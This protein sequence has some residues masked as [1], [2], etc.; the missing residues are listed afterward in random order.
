GANLRI[1]SGVRQGDHISVHYDP[2]IAKL[3]VWDE[4]RAGA[5][6]RLRAALAA[7]EVVGVTTNA[8]FLSAI[9]GHPAFAAG[10]VDTGFIPRHADILLPPP[11]TLSDPVL[12]LSCLGVLLERRA[13]A[14]REAAASNDPYSPWAQC[15]GWRLNEDAHDSLHL[16][17][18][19]TDIVLPLIY[20]T[21]GYELFLPGGR[22]EARG[23]L[24]AEG[25]LSAEIGPVRRN[26]GFVQRGGALFLFVDGRCH[27]LTLVDPLPSDE[28][29]AVAGG[30]TAVMHGT[31]IALLV[32]PG[33]KVIKGQPLVVMEAMKME[34]TLKAPADGTVSRLHYAVGAL[35]EEGAALVD[36]QADE[37]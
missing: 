35:V 31:I 34:H 25:R 15:D 17:H 8:A 36:F 27:H 33:A 11:E 28:S 7:T 5:V 32:D 13:V 19:E 23:Q 24:R 4:D 9:A 6:R 14:A 3:I 12:A 20:R 37:V 22:V 18:A 26:A 10:D 1:D 21:W 16:R 2:M 29:D 30:V